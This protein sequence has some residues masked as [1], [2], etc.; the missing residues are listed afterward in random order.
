MDTG[1][2]A[3]F[4]AALLLVQNTEAHC[5]PEQADLR[6]AVSQYLGEAGMRRLE[7]GR[8]GQSEDE[9]RYPLCASPIFTNAVSPDAGMP[10][11]RGV[12]GKGGG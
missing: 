2:S 4:Q 10:G 1:Q 7:A 8:S 3:I 5:H 6:K 9:K 11:Q 12:R